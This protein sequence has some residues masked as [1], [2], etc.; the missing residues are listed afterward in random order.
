MHATVIHFSG[1]TVESAWNDGNAHYHN[2]HFQSATRKMDIPS[3]EVSLLKLTLIWQRYGSPLCQI[4]HD[5]MFA[6][7]CST[8]AFILKDSTVL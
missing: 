5:F 6:E 4:L 7:P 3:L 1:V 8:H 2:I